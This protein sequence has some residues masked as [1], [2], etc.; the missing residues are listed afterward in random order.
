MISTFRSKT[1]T[2]TRRLRRAN[3]GVEKVFKPNEVEDYNL[4]MG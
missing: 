1:I 3:R 2:K 4:H